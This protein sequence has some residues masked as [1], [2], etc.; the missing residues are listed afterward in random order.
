ME[1]AASKVCKKCKKEKPQ[2]EYYVHGISQGALHKRL[3]AKCKS[4]YLMDRRKKYWFPRGPRKR[5]LKQMAELKKF[6]KMTESPEQLE[7][8][9]EAARLEWHTRDHNK[10]K[11]RNKLAGEIRQGRMPRATELGCR[12]CV[13]EAVQYRHLSWEKEHW[14]DVIP[15]CRRCS[16]K[17]DMIKRDQDAK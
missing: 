2:S 4:C 11:A 7:A 3:Y 6:I 14:L 1:L 15:V 17:L 10:R 13:R 12:Y 9:R 8:R 5:R 16:I